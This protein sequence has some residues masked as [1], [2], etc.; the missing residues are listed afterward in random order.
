M[1]KIHA[2]SDASGAL[3][4]FGPTG[5][6]KG[7]APHLAVLL[8]LGPDIAPRAVTGDKGYASKANRAAARAHA[9]SRR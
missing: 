1:T 5:G 7:D 2:K 4:G 8:D 9:A 6:E 3:T